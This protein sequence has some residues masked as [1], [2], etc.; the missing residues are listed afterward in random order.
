MSFLNQLINLRSVNNVMFGKTATR[1]LSEDAFRQILERERARTDRYGGV[2]SLLVFHIGNPNGN[3]QKRQF[4]A[5]IIIN[6]VRP[7][8]D[9]GWF[10]KY[11]LGVALPGTAHE[12]AIKLAD[13]ICQK[14][15][16]RK[17]TVP[18]FEVY[19]YPNERLKKNN[20]DPQIFRKNRCLSE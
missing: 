6:R 1:I 7:T 9:V 5:E 19:T 16:A 10:E 11:T 14:I 18:R 8:D 12:G 15:L 3:L 20:K 17:Q 2:F 13:D 4:I